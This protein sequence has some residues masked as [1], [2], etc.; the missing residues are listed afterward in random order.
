MTEEEFIRRLRA[1]KRALSD[2]VRRRAP[3]IVGA[4]AVGFYRENYRRGG[5]LDRGFHAWPITRRQVEPSPGASGRYPPLLSKRNRLFGAIKYE[6]HDSSVSIVNETP[7]AA[8][9]NDGGTTNPKVTPSMRKYFWAMYYKRGGAKNPAAEKYKWLA[10]TK[11]NRL[12]VKIPQRKFLYESE[13]LSKVV[14]N[15]LREGIKGIIRN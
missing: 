14:R 8:V 1:N 9:H 6:P 12:K 5:Y 2:Y 15:T 13:E 7:Y 10:L 3:R 4:K 11:K